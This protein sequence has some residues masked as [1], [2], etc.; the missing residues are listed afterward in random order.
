MLS[1]LDSSVEA[2]KKQK[3]SIPGPTYGVP[4]LI[5]ARSESHCIIRLVV[6]GDYQ[7][8]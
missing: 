4:K 5:V 1:Y 6:I 8:Q 2:K 7:N 3:L